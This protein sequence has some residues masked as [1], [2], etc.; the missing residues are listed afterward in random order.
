MLI[1]FVF[2]LV[3]N[4]GGAGSYAHFGSVANEFLL[5]ILFRRRFFT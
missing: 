2:A 4:F 1:W 3:I 5:F